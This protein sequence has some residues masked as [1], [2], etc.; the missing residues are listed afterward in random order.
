MSAPARAPRGME[1]AE[2]AELVLT[3]TNGTDTPTDEMG[4]QITW[5]LTDACAND[6]LL[7]V[8]DATRPMWIVA[9]LDGEG[10]PQHW[11]LRYELA[12]AAAALLRRFR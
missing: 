3:L 1:P 4:R 11:T 6:V 10:Q 7:R 8:I 5:L 12:E 2:A 9:A